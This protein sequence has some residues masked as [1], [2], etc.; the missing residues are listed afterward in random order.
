VDRAPIIEAV[1]VELRSE[2]IVEKHETLSASVQENSNE[3]GPD[4]TED[5]AAI[6]SEVHP[7]GVRAHDGNNPR[8]VRPGSGTRISRGVVGTDDDTSAR[9]GLRGID[10]PGADADRADI[11]KRIYRPDSGWGKRSNEDIV[12]RAQRGGSGYGR[13][14]NEN[15]EKRAQ[16]GGKSWGKRFDDHGEKRAQRGGKSWGRSG[17]SLIERAYA[18]IFE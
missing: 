18:A 3:D 15:I 4:A 13:R 1:P 11:E 12:K 6:E 10:S 2:T 14:S 9:R 5:D 17:T 7:R 8:A 16:R